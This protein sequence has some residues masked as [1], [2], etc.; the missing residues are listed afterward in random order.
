MA[1]LALT[2]FPAAGMRTADALSVWLERV[3][4]EALGAGFGLVTFGYENCGRTSSA[5]MA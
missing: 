4:G 1:S 3:G 2:D 5:I